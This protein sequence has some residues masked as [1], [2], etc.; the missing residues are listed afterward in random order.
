MDWQDSAEQAAFRREVKALIDERLPAYYR[1]LSDEGIEEGYEGGWVADR[2]SDDSERRAAAEQWGNAISERGWFA[3]QWP[4]GSGGAGLRVDQPIDNNAFVEL[5]MEGMRTVPGRVA[6]NF[7]SGIG[8]EFDLGEGE[9]KDMEKEL[10]KF[11]IA[12]AR[13]KF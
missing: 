3:P 12:V 2:R 4:K 7:A 13:Q 11:R 5:H 9:R 10:I 6:R 1:R 8:V